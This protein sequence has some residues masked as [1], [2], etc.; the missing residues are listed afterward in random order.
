MNL[1]TSWS[2]KK[3][4][5]GPDKLHLEMLRVPILIPSMYSESFSPPPPS[6]GNILMEF[7]RL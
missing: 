5:L 3:L 6:L 4:C 1:N 2:S 7:Q